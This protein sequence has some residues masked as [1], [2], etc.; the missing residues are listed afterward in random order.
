M[1]AFA[2][3]MDNKTPEYLRKFPGGKIPAFEGPDGF[4]LTETMAISKYSAYATSRLGIARVNPFSFTQSRPSH[5]NLMSS[6]EVPSRR[7]L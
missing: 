5:P 6:W 4:L 2:H 7:R 3:A 1:P